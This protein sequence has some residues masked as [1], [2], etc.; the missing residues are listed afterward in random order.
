M[1]FQENAKGSLSDQVFHKIE[2]AIL[3]GQYSPGESA[4]RVKAFRRTWSQQDACAG[5]A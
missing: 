4:D 5:G 2:D 3:N 1:L